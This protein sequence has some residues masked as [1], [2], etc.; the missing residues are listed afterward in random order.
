[1]TTLLI[2]IAILIILIVILYIINGTY[3][4]YSEKKDYDEPDLSNLMREDC[5][6]IYH[7]D[8]NDTALMYIHGFT[9]NVSEV[10]YFSDLSIKDGF[11]V[12]SILLP[13]AGTNKEDFK[14]TNF[15]Q[16]YNYARDSYL[17]YRKNYKNFFIAGLSMGGSITIRLAEE[18]NDN[19]EL[20]PTGIVTFS[21]AVFLNS[22]I[23]NGVFKNPALYFSRILS[24]IVDEIPDKRKKKMEDG[25][26]RKISY[27]GLFL[28][29]IH[30]L[31][32]SLKTI[33]KDLSKIDVPIFL[34]HAKDDK[35]VPFENVFYIPKKIKSKIIKMRLYDL[36]NFSH[37]HHPITVFDSTRDD[38]YNNF[39]NFIKEQIKELET[40]KQWYYFFIH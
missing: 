5:N 17:K 28:K 1:M 36:S 39:I 2:C 32:L 24:L 40:I 16:W 13:G 10:R 38:L 18:F 19:S 23:E 12:I 20:K 3:I 6:P 31:K 37:S 21:A 34:A 26:D 4:F 25:I 11:D 15:T 9:G 33:K 8:N 35:V 14:K 29:Q 22:F 30:S 27:E 7:I